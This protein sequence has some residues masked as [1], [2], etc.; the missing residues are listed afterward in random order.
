MTEAIYLDI[1]GTLRD[2]RWGIPHSAVW[3]LNQ[4]RMKRI[5]II[6]CTGR[7]LGSIQNDVWE[8]SWDGM[9]SGGGCLVQ[10]QGETL[11]EKQF[12]PRFIGQVLKHASL[13]NLPLVLETQQTVFMN[14]RA[15]KFYREDVD[16][17]AA[18]LSE[19]QKHRMI[20]Q[21][22]I[23]YED[24]LGLFSNETPCVHK[25]CIMGTDAE[26]SAFKAL[27]ETEMELIQEKLWNGRWYLELLPK[28]CDKGSAVRRMNRKLGISKK[29]TLSFGDSEND[30]PM[31]METEIAVVVG[32]CNPAVGNYAS[33]V[34]EPVTEDGVYK[35]LIRR[36]IIQPKNPGGKDA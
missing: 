29:N 24:N 16:R 14:G 23:P 31:M 7:N 6:I 1:D 12:S 11:W 30:I 26:T 4:C 18:G 10:Y 9:I 25:I 32:G 15:A 17:K 22:K 27:A 36:S 2:E 20:A 28:G 13:R 21:N 33:S 35:E 8:L 3:A 19:P 34:C 5:K